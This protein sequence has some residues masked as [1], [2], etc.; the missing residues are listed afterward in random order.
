[1]VTQKVAESRKEGPSNGRLE[2][3][4]LLSTYDVHCSPVIIRKVYPSA[5]VLF[6]GLVR[7]CKR[8]AP[9]AANSIFERSERPTWRYSVMMQQSFP[10]E[11]H[12][13]R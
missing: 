8:E 11:W 3:P 5:C 9:Q 4:R 10:H 6:T 1:M 13:M 2:T 12:G 7:W